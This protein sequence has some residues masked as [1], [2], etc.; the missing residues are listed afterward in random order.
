MPHSTITYWSLWDQTAQENHQSFKRWHFC[1]IS[2]K[3][4]QSASLSIVDG[5]LLRQEDY[6][7]GRPQSTWQ[8]ISADDGATMWH[9]AWVGEQILARPKQSRFGYER[10]LQTGHSGF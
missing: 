10:Q 1:N 4:A 2:R 8:F 5:A 6:L 7:A 3:A 9:G